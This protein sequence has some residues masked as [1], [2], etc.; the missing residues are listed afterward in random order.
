MPLLRD[1]GLAECII[2]RGYYIQLFCT[3]AVTVYTTALMCS[4]LFFHP[5]SVFMVAS[6]SKQR[7]RLRKH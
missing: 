1:F 5:Q 2:C 4:D 7:H 3:A 6:H